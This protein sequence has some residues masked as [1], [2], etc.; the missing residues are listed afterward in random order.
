MGAL[1]L[2]GQGMVS[3]SGTRV[4]N[5]LREYDSRLFFARNPDTGDFCIFINMGP[6][7]PPY[8]LYGFRHEPSVEEALTV[9]K[10]RD[11][12]RRGD[13]ILKEMRRSRDQ[14]RADEDYASQQGAE[15]YAEGLE[16]YLHDQGEL[17]YFR[18]LRPTRKTAI[19]RG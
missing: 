4:D 10:D 2:P 17:R 18:S 11:T 6:S 9:V 12:Q 7:D 16:S 3:L 19:R 8:P 15:A 5:A 14:A 13:E 1:W